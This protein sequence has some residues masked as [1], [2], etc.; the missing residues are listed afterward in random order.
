[1]AEPNSVVYLPYVNNNRG[2]AIESRE[3]NPSSVGNHFVG[4]SDDIDIRNL[5]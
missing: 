5:W 2:R 3:A 4:P 1:M